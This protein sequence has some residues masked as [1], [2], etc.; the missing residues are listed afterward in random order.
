MLN[1]IID[2][3]GKYDLVY[4]QEARNINKDFA[5]YK[6][7]KVLNEKI[8]DSAIQGKKTVK[9]ELFRNKSYENCKLF[10]QNET[11]H[12]LAEFCRKKGYDIYTTL[13][14]DDK[15]EDYYCELI[16]SWDTKKNKNP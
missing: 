10:L 3:M 12:K 11:V 8:Y 7:I 4:A 16:L 5:V 1:Q 13:N 14:E 9:M 6:I 15:T 2:E